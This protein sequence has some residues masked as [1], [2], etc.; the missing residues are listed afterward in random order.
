MRWW[1]VVAPA[2]S[3]IGGPF[4][5]VLDRLDHREDEPPLVSAQFIETDD[6]GWTPSLLRTPTTRFDQPPIL[7]P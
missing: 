5:R 4:G 3:P 1:R 6:T 2:A 7:R